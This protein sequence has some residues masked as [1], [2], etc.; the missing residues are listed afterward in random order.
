VPPLIPRRIQ[1]TALPGA[2]R[3]YDRGATDRLLQQVAESYEE[4]WLERNALREQVEGLEAEIAKLNERE[5]HV[6]EALLAAERTAEEVRTSAQRDAEALVTE[7]R[8]ERLHLEAVVS[9]LSGLVEKVHS[10]LSAFLTDTLEQL[11]SRGF[12][13][14]AQQAGDGRGEPALVDDLSTMRQTAAE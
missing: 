11:R 12:A 10:E 3:G 5:R 7:A 8:A 13:D 6:A 9:H 4:L 2:I 14:R 1:T